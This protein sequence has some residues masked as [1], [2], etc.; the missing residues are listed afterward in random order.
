MNLTPAK[1][2]ML[3]LVAV[4]ALIGMYIVKGLFAGAKP[5][6]RNPYVN[7]PLA[8]A[9]LSPGTRI[10]RNHIGFGPFPEKELKNEKPPAK[11]VKSL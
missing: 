11:D 8:A 1:V 6:A 9:D 7:I 10:T 3:M 4:A 2:T 5:V